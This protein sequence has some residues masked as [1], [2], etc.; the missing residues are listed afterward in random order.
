MGDSTENTSF[1]RLVIESIPKPEPRPSKLHHYTSFNTAKEILL[2]NTLHLSHAAFSND[3][4]EL[5][6]GLDVM[7]KMFGES[8][9]G[10]FDTDLFLSHLYYKTQPYIF[11]LSESE[12]M[13]SQWEMYSGRN[14]CCITFNNN[15][16]NSLTEEPY[17]GLAPVIYEEAEQLK[18]LEGLNTQRRQPEYSEQ[19]QSSNNLYFFVSTVFLKNPAWSH[20]KEWRIVKIIQEES[21]S[22]I[23]YRSGSRFLKPYIRL[24]CEP[25]PITEIRVGP[26][27]DQD[28]LVRSM[29]H[30]VKMTKGYED[31]AISRSTV[32]VSPS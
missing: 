4:T 17:V 1:A 8:T 26:A 31:V 3:P 27:D 29:E 24:F 7:K 6:H 10:G 16:I 19:E 5:G 12:D 23:Q 22:D 20:E 2:S 25:L 28:R 9:Q 21:F 30:L 13:L 11:C 14:G 18:Y 32:R 15:E